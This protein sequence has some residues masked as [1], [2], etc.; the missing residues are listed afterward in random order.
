MELRS[1]RYFVVLAEELHFGRAARRLAITQPPLSI[2]IRNLENELE[3]QLLVR[4]RR[5]VSLTDPGR[6]FLEQARVVLARASDAIEIAGRQPRRGGPTCH[7]IH[8][9]EHLHGAAAGAARVRV[10]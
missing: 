10:E 4:D 9:G 8:V 3:V 6:A 1:L 7:R 2:A 5:Q